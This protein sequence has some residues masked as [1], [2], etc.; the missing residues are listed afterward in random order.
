VQKVEGRVFW[1][2]HSYQIQI[3]QK[4]VPS[5][6]GYGMMPIGWQVGSRK[7]R[8]HRYGADAP[9]AAVPAPI[10][11]HIINR[12]HPLIYK[13]SRA[14]QLSSMVILKP[15]LHVLPTQMASC[16]FHTL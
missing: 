5:Q 3:R 11:V 13:L 16:M 10:A 15:T 6:T 14:H 12:S 9:A 4:Y 7:K 1:A 2:T 8:C